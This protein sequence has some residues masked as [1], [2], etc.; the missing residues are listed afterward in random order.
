MIDLGDW[1]NENHRI[2]DNNPPKD[3]DDLDE[4]N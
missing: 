4:F 2:P 3:L 1:A